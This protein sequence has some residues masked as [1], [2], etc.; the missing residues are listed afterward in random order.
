MRATL[1]KL[2]FVQ[3]WDVMC[4]YDAINLFKKKYIIGTVIIK[5]KFKFCNILCFRE[6]ELFD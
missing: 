5:S 4:K 1:Y 2:K 6:I 3:Y